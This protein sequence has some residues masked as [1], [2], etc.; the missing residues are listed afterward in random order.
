MLPLKLCQICSL[1]PGEDKL[2]FSVFIELN[3]SADVI[4]HRFRKTIIRS[5]A[6]LS[7][8]HAQVSSVLRPFAFHDD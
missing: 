7:Y 4:K 3:E 1:L 2:A 5:C 8:D 6:Q